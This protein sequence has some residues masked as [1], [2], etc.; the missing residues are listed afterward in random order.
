MNDC[1]LPWLTKKPL[2]DDPREI[3]DG[4]RPGERRQSGPPNGQ[5]KP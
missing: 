1:Y 4:P 5:S 3:L 2:V